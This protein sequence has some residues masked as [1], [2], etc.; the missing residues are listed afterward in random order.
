MFQHGLCGSAGQTTDVF[1]DDINW[2]CQTLECRGHGASECGEFAALSIENFTNDLAD[3]IDS[4]NTGPIVIGGISMGAAISLRLAVKH[5]NLVAGLVLARPAWTSHSAPENLAPN[6]EVA[7][8]L[9]QYEPGE[10]KSRFEQSPTAIRLK[11]DAPDNLK[12]LLSFFSRTPIDE[13]RALLSAIAAD[14]PG[15]GV[16]EIS[17]LRL[18]SLIIGTAQDAVHPL[19]LAKELAELIPEAHLMEITS[20]A[21]SPRQYQA[22]F[23]SALRYFLKGF[24]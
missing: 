9:E 3:F 8:F 17:R 15:V 13:T 20:K 23:R 14:G 19:S 2:R 1:P 11:R 18:R 10:A 6:R 24:E 5:P 12:S 22:E 7:R 21:R 4:L 16:E